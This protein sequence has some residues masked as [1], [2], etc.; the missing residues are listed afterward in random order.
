GHTTNGTCRVAR[1][2]VSSDRPIRQRRCRTAR[3]PAAKPD[4]PPYVPHFLPRR[5]RSNRNAS[6][7][8]QFVKGNSSDNSLRNHRPRKYSPRNFKPFS[9]VPAPFE[10]LFNL[11]FG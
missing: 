3:S 4:G 6:I 7:S 1:G 9:G 11:A 10:P 5:L 8:R 2:R